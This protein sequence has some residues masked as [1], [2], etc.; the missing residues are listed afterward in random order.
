M[1]PLFTFA[2]VVT[3][4]ACAWRFGYVAPPASQPP[5][6]VVDITP[7]PAPAP[8]RP[9][10]SKPKPDPTPT[11]KPAANADCELSEWGPFSE[12]SPWGPSAF[13]GLEYRV[14][15]RTRT[16]IT[17]PSG[18]GKPCPPLA[19][20]EIETRWKSNATRRP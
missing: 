19:D 5:T 17:H 4:A 7:P 14:R 16:V 9:A 3:L 13:P 6:E 12:W 18:V 8:D 20:A 1:R 10:P 2:F 11:T 15:L